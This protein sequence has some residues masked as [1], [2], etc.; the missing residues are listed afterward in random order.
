MEPFLAYFKIFHNL[1]TPIGGHHSV[2]CFTET[3]YSMYYGGTRQGVT[4]TEVPGD[5]VGALR[6]LRTETIV[7][8]RTSEVHIL[9][10]SVY[11]LVAVVLQ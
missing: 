7:P 5:E 9:T 1:Q 11:N 8:R 2:P 6:G 3:G 10:S 4:D